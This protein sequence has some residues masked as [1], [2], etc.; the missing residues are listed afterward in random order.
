MKR[1]TGANKDLY[2]ANAAKIIEKLKEGGRCSYVTLGDPTFYSTYW[3]LHGAIENILSER[4][5]ENGT[6]GKFRLKTNVINGVSSFH[7]SFG[8]IG[9]PFII[10]ESSVLITVPVKKDLYEIEEEIKFIAGKKSRPQSIVFMKAGGYV[11]DILKAFG[12]VCG[13]GPEPGGGAGVSGENKKYR[14]YLI[15]KSKLI[16]EFWEKDIPDFDYFSVLIGV[17]V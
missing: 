13:S 1:S 8:L 15:E 7:Y 9:E 6:V 3:G 4:N 12:N 14:L 10:K 2:A 17:F 5:G 16:E 11:G